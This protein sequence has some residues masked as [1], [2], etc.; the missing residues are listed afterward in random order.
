MSVFRLLQSRV[1]EK[2]GVHSPSPFGRWLDGTLTHIEEGTITVNFHV[3]PEMCNPA[4]V[5]HGG[6][7]AAMMDEV[8]GMTVFSLDLD[9][10]YMSVNLNIDYLFGARS[11]EHVNVRS[12]VIRKGKKVVHTECRIYD[13]EGRL[14]TKA[15]SNLI[16]TSMPAGNTNGQA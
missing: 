15:T 3:R 10:F 12:E 14:L 4:G 9:H 5:L 8:M 13:A 1:G 16:A 11:G 6:V 2:L 7:A